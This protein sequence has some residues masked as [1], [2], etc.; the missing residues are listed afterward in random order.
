MKKVYTIIFVLLVFA[1]PSCEDPDDYDCDECLSER[2]G[3]GDLKIKLTINH[4][5][6]EV[7]VTVF[8]DNINGHIIVT[9]IVNTE[10]YYVEELP[11]KQY[12]VVQAKYL[13]GNDTIYA[14][15]DDFM[16]PKESYTCEETCWIIKGDVIDVRLKY[17]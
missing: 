2:P 8:F 1:I 7:P 12:Y 16:E 4:E 6:P 5:N 10:M 11:L 17:D 13:V 14:I 15:D 3:V 9:D